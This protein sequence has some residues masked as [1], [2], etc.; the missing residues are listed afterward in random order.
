VKS[1]HV[2]IAMIEKF[3]TLRPCVNFGYTPEISLNIARLG[4]DGLPRNFSI[5][6]ET[7]KSA[8]GGCSA[9][10]FATE[11]GEGIQANLF[12]WYGP[13]LS[14]P[15]LRDYQHGLRAMERIGKRMEAMQ[16]VRGSSVD[17]ADAMGRFLEASGIIH[18]YSRPAGCRELNHTRGEWRIESI[19][20]FV[21]RAR[22]S[23]YVKP[24][25]LNQSEAV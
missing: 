10:I 14:F 16:R 4:N 9:R 6:Y 1:T 24:A 7:P 12:S 3:E 8:N 13:A 19:G 25:T 17:C 15:D 2:E 5:D 22:R 23:L 20:D 18:V 21:N 11:H